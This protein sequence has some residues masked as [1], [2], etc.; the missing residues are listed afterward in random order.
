MV[1]GASCPVSPLCRTDGFKIHDA[2]VISNLAG[3]HAKQ[4][5]LFVVDHFL[6]MGIKDYE[7]E[8]L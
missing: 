2:R 4:G 5:G 7:F 8:M 1:A 3:S 6:A